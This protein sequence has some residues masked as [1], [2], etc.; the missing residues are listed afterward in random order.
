[1][2]PVTAYQPAP[3]Y[4]PPAAYEPP[5]DPT[6]VMGRRIGAFVI[7]LAIGVAL[8]FLMLWATVDGVVFEGVN[9]CASTD[10]SQFFSDSSTKSSTSACT[11]DD[12]FVIY[13][14]TDSTVIKTSSTYALDAVLLAYALLVFILFQG[15]TGA[16]AGKALF[17]VRTVNEEGGP[18][19]IG[20]AFVRWVLWIVDW[21][22]WICVV[23]ITGGIAAFSSKGHRRVGD[24]AA[25]TYVID[26]KRVGEPVAVPSKDAPIVAYPPTAS[27]APGASGG[28]Q[29]APTP[30]TPAAPVT[31]AAPG[32]TGAAESEPVW[33]PQR[34]QYVKWD[35]ASGQWLGYDERASSW[36]PLT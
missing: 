2:P 25:K 28:T 33:D 17:G 22:P 12:T 26:K 15:L 10:N 18:P 23:P 1:M 35:A 24:M 32:A 27:G 36:Q 19:G 11:R 3:G 14:G 21:F 16:T 5:S 6:S 7:D 8:V 31:P 29:Y 30:D 13:D 4:Q 9:L 34:N 20:R